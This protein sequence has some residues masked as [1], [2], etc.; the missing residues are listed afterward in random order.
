MV[1]EKRA[2]RDCSNHGASGL[3]NVTTTAST[4]SFSS[5]TKS[6]KRA[7]LEEKMEAPRTAFLISCSVASSMP[8]S[9]T[10]WFLGLISDPKM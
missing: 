2:R 4:K 8:W 6:F 10:Q 1:R 5:S 7:D 3:W 9:L